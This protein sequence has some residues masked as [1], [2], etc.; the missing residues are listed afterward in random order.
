MTVGGVSHAGDA[1]AAY[2]WMINADDTGDPGTIGDQGTQRCLPNTTAGGATAATA[3][4]YADTCPWPSVRNTAGAAPIVAQGNQ[5]DLNAAKPLSG[6]PVGKYLISV[7]AD[8][9]KI[10][11]QHFTVA[12]GSSQLVAVRMNA[13]PLPL[14]TLRLQVF[15]DTN[16]VDA[17]YEVDAERGLAGFTATLTDVLGLVSTDYYGNALCTIYRH[18]AAGHMMFSGTK[19][20]I[21]A[22]STGKCVSNASGQIVIPNLGSNRYAATVAPPATQIGQWVQTTTLEGGHDHDIWEQEGSTGYDTEQTKGAELV[23]AV[24]FGFVRKLPTIARSATGTGTIKGVAIAGLPY[25]GGQNGQVSPETGLAGVKS[26]G[27]IAHPWIALSDLN[28]GDQQ[29][30]TAQGN[31]DGSFQIANV[32]TGSYQLSIWDDDQDYILW[33]FNVEVT[34]GQITNVGNKIIVGWFTH[35]YGKVFIDSNGNG[36]MDP[37]EKAVPSFGL[38]VRERDNSLMDQATNTVNTSDSGAYDI[39]E[40]YPLGKWLVLE[41]FNTRYKTTGVTYQGENDPKP[42]TQLGSMVDINFLPIIGLGGEIDWGVQPYDPGT[43]GGIVGTVTYDTTRN[44]LDPADAATETYQPGIS[45]VPVHLYLPVKCDSTTPADQCR[46][47]YQ[48]N[49][50]GSMKRGPKVADDYTSE[51]W[52]PPRGCT[53]RQYNGQPLTDQQALPPFGSAANAMCVEAP[54]MGVATGVSDAAGGSQTVNGNYGFSTSTINQYPVGDSHN[55]APAHDLPLYADLG[56]AGYPEQDLA[57]AD[58]LVG[59]DI[60]NDPV[61]GKPMYKVTTEAD[62][63][64]FS[65]DSYLPQENY[66]PASAAIA[67][68][69]DQGAQLDTP[70]PPSQPPSQQA[71]IISPCAGALHKVTVTNPDFLAAGGSP[72]EGQQRPYCT[73]KLVTVRTGQSTAPNFNLFTDVAIPTKFWGLTLNDLGLTLDKRSVNYGEAQGMPYVPVGLY[74]WSGRLDY[75][76]HTDFNGLYEAL[77]PSTDT[78]NCPVPAGPC[79]NMYR[80]VGNDPGQPGALNADY[81]PRFRTIATN[82]QA[83]PGLYTVTD[84]APTQVATTALAPDTTTVNPTQCDL[85]ANTPQ[86]LAVNRP[87]VRKGDANRTVTISGFGFGAASGTVTLGGTSLAT[88]GWSDTSIT[89]TVPDGTASGPR[90][91]A[92]TRSDG[93]TG[94]NGITLQIL[95]ALGSSVPGT[96]A[97]NPGLIEVGP[98]AKS[99]DAIAR[100]ATV[101]AG[102]EAAKPAPAVAGRRNVPPQPAKPYWLVVVWPNAQSSANPQGQYTEN[103]IVH[104]RVHIQGVGPGGFR[105]DGS[106][107]PGSILDGSGFNPDNPSGLAWVALLGNLR[108]SGNLAVPDAAVVTVLDDPATPNSLVPSS[109]PLSLDGFQVTGGAQ[110]DFPA[111]INELTGQI[112]TPYGAAGALVTQGGGIYLHSN[113]RGMQVTDNVI[114]GNGGSYGGAVRVG[115]PYVGDNRNYDLNLSSNQIRDNGGTNL[116][117]GVGLFTGSDGYRI[118]HNAICGNFSAEYGGAISAFGYQENAGPNKGGSLTGN[119]IWFNASYDEG[120]GV[121][122]AGEL[123]ADPTKLSAGTGR[124]RIDGNV[125]QANL[126]NDDGGG[127]RL[128]QV[129]GSHVTTK[130]QAQQQAIAIT[131]NMVANN[132]SAHEG[133]GIALDDAPFVT[134]ANDTVAKNLTTATAVTSDGSA[135]PAGLSTSTNSDPLQAQ[136][137]VIDSSASTLLATTWSKPVLLNDVFSDNRA[138]NFDGGVVCGIDSAACPGI[139]NWDMGVADDPAATLAPTHSLLQTGTQVSDDGSNVIG[140]AGPGFVSEYNVDVNILASRTYPAFRQAI[141]VAQLLPPYLMGDYHLGASSSPAYG[142]GAASTDVHW[143]TQNNRGVWRGWTYPVTAPTPDIDGQARPGVSA[144]YDAGADQLAP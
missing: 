136:L 31:A 51:T 140:S 48:L 1:I 61:D 2:K 18:D 40:T 93:R 105:P 129:T 123:P 28:G 95:N 32:A 55:P 54:M 42:T 19:P 126:A 119:R 50:D 112:S 30:Y 99:A 35:I 68:Q 120:G 142:I 128:L 122:I 91:L 78:Y 79:P 97:D 135:A 11:G 124:V 113:V 33:S 4:S 27:P 70:T 109:Y 81:N 96:T 143:G 71:G 7:T 82:F 65:G 76:A 101:Q 141:I 3:T 74:D 25:I 85:G 106:F 75:T 87:Y 14:S 132:V 137:A 36:R 130:N 117:G 111:N 38:T 98:G 121:M 100:Y 89:V 15:N 86:L 114:R 26:G 66:P 60:P 127:I 17:T 69:Q 134:I 73:D 49:G 63:N 139:T 88:S 62:V 84:E 125:I 12:S 5:D 133:G 118:D 56:A 43:N 131:N 67:N 138:G 80:F 8:G 37:G 10:D 103:V 57:A 16:P 41:A 115:T 23:P 29:V 72:F 64:V 52:A 104:H 102:L 53:A 9:F 24:Q 92:V 45:G 144:R 58:Y 47:G 44:E 46:Q 110:S 22:S 13:T 90:A 77:V 39:R 34:N 107:V 94:Y 20:I 83:W 59:V 21:A 6:L 108:Y 116:A